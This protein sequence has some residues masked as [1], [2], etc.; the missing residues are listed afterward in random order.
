[1]QS[2]QGRWCAAGIDRA[3]AC[4]AATPTYLC[5][6]MQG[7][8]SSET[9]ITARQGLRSA[10]HPVL[11]ETEHRPWPLPSKP[12]IGRQTWHDLLFAHWPV[13]AA[14]LRR[15][16]P[17]ELTIQEK[18]GTSWVGLACFR[19]SDVSVRGLP[20]LPAVGRFLE[21]NVRLYVEKH[22][23]PGVWFLSLDA[24]STL[25]VLT[26]RTLLNLPYVRA[27]MSMAPH[28]EGI[29]FESERRRGGGRFCAD[30][31]P[32]R[33]PRQARPGTL[34]HFLTERYCLYT[35]VLGTLA[36][37]E[38]H[39]RPWPLQDALGRVDAAELL[40]ADGLRT[41]EA[42]PLLHFARRVD[43]LVWAPQM[44]TTARPPAR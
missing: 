18:D 21:L 2:G 37:V 22:G 19:L 43:A 17:P 32:V 38:I 40:F 3:G 25:A 36:R 4:A 42:P 14:A 31:L 30:Y 41:G 5:T 33:A 29:R 27:R 6:A 34:E 26:A 28:E 10:V 23:K 35:R 20:E 7:G 15:Y 12:W 39:H 24:S 13:P 11:E 8:T 16:V 44:V 1:M 9:G